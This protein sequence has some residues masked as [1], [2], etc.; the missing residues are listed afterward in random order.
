M[1]LVP[2]FSFQMP[3][4]V[5]VARMSY[6]LPF[7]VQTSVVQFYDWNLALLGAEICFRSKLR[8]AQILRRQCSFLQWSMDFLGKLG[9]KHLCPQSAVLPGTSCDLQDVCGCQHPLEACQKCRRSG[10][11]PHLLNQN[12]HFNKSSADSDTH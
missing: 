12:P 3:Y 2:C 7:R 11:A 5:V 6:L 1:Q 9:F 10:P 8:I 4:N